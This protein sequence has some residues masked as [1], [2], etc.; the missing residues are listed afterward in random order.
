MSEGFLSVLSSNV[1][2]LRDG[3][4]EEVT[5]MSATFEDWVAFAILTFATLA[6]PF[7]FGWWK[8]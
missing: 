4:E 7:I 3:I 1:G 5:G 8:T 2:L 6:L